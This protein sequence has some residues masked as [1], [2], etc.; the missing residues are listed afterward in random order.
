MHVIDTTK[1]IQQVQQI[2]QKWKNLSLRSDWVNSKLFFGRFDIAC[3][4]TKYQDFFLVFFS[5][6]HS[7]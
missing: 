2:C 7:Q 4:K 3:I 1:S 6:I 5:T